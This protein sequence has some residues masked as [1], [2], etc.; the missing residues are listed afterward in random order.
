MLAALRWIL[1]RAP[2]S[3]QEAA[4]LLALGSRGA[5]RLRLVA[6]DEFLSSYRFA[7]AV[8]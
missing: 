1:G 7:A 4:E 8:A 3:S 2:R 6:S 5:L